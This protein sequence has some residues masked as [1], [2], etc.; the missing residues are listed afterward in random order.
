MN[1]VYPIHYASMEGDVQF[2]SNVVH[3]G[4]SKEIIFSH[5]TEEDNCYFWTPIHWASYYGKD[6]IIEGFINYGVSSDLQTSKYLQTPLH[7]SSISGSIQCAEKLLSMGAEINLQD[8]FGETVLHKTARKGGDINLLYLWLK[9]GIN[10]M[11]ENKDGQTAYRVAELHNNQNFCQTVKNYLRK[12]GDHNNSYLS[13]D[14]KCQSLNAS[15]GNT[16]ERLR[17]EKKRS[18][19]GNNGDCL[20]NKEEASETVAAKRIKVCRESETEMSIKMQPFPALDLHTTI[21]N[22]QVRDHEKN[23]NHIPREKFCMRA[24]SMY[25]L[26]HGL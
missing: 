11:L 14:D 19:C 18:W 5:F 4:K 7:M 25:D 22:N 21:E 23:I 12:S 3:S 10:L 2:L 24:M 26:Y 15:F 8:K 16:N 9:N 13:F 17:L 6:K 20:Q 1:A